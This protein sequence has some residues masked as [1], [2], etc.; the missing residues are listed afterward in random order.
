MRRLRLAADTEV[1][2]TFKAV[3]PR[4]VLDAA[5]MEAATKRILE[6]Y[7]IPVASNVA[8]KLSNTSLGQP[9]PF[10]P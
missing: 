9:S 3:E 7:R 2:V 1:W 5:Q 4:I 8:T 10:P 6:R